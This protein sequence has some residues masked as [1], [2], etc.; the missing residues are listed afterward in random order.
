[1]DDKKRAQV[2]KI[3]DLARAGR[4]EILAHFYQRREVRSAA[5]FVGGSAEMAARAFQS[6]AAAVMLCGP[7]YLAGEI[8]RHGG[9]KRPLLIPRADIAC[10]LSDAVSLEEALAAKSACP[11]ALLVADIRA[12]REIKAA[13]D[14]EISPENVRE[15]LARTGG[16]PLIV[17][18]GPQ[19]ADQA[20]FGGRVAGR[21]AKAVC[22]VHELARPDELAAAKETWPRA[23]VAAHSL[24]RP[25]L[26]A[27]ADFIG[28]A[29]AIRDFCLQSP[30]REFIIVAE[31][32]LAEYLAELLPEK[33][34]HET[35]AEIFC[36]NMKLTNLKA[37]IGCLE[38]FQQKQ[39]GRS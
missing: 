35:E 26:L 12:G 39:R 36:P 30:A 28:N 20:G 32:G 18:P 11:E 22:Q 24:C 14:L 38:D 29:S 25:D 10:P 21:W 3:R 34:F 13:A 2:E 33:I 7:S 4:V 1:M 23:V 8:E 9:L 37:I 16:R 17:L 31:T 5:D 19:L 6:R 27:L 15:V